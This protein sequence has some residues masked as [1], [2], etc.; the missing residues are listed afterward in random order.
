MLLVPFIYLMEPGIMEKCWI[1]KSTGKGK[2]SGLISLFMKVTGIKT[3][4]LEKGEFFILMD[5]PTKEIGFREGWTGEEATSI[6]TVQL[7]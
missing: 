6:L 1:R 4:R 2:W 3:L 5:K 7:T